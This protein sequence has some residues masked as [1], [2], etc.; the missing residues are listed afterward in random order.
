MSRQTLGIL[1]FVFVALA[2]IAS[3]PW[4]SRQ[5][6]PQKEG[7]SFN[8]SLSGFTQEAV[9]KLTIKEREELT[10]VKQDGTW[11]VNDYPAS[12]TQIGDL[13]QALA[14]SKVDTLVSK[15]PESHEKLGVA[16][17]SGFLLAITQDDST[18][19]FIIGKPG[20]VIDSFYARK[21]DSHEVYL[22]LS[23]VRD[24]LTQTV[25]EW[26]NKTLVD[27]S[28]IEV[29]KL[30]ITSSGESL[31]VAKTSD[32]DWQITKAD[33][34]ATLDKPTIDHLVSSLSPLDAS[35]FLS[36]EET[37]EFKSARKKTVFTIFGIEENPIAK[38]LFYEK[39]ENAWWAQVEDKETY[40]RIPAYK[41]T[42]VLLTPEQFFSGAD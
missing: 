29:K 15:N 23:A 25:S 2:A 21:K 10:L 40:Y 4:W 7:T 13:F 3:Y 39:D 19:E 17:D 26:R 20:P 41:L 1:F 28:G 16:E 36:E 42:D 6:L 18:S 22:I 27:L 31:I 5:L 11:Q 14:N 12:P 35:G 33:Q 38:I 34:Q 30:E 8:F 32:E 37:S 24:K 9:K